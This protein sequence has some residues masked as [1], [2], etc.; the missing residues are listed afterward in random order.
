MKTLVILTCVLGV[1][2]IAEA[3]LESQNN[4]SQ[5]NSSQNN[6][7]SNTGTCN[8]QGNLPIPICGKN[9]DTFDNICEANCKSEEVE[10]NQECPCPPSAPQVSSKSATNVTI[11]SILAK[12]TNSFNSTIK[13]VSVQ[14]KPC[15]VA[16]KKVCADNGTTFENACKAENSGLVRIKSGFKMIVCI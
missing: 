13:E 1:S 11:A 3:Q 16:I 6:R 7:V 2:I 4:S 8:C 9:G 12:P 5:N 10:C 14:P 15:S